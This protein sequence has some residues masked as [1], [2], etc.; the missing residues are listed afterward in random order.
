MRPAAIIN[1]T[2]TTGLAGAVVLMAVNRDSFSV[3]ALESYLGAMGPWGILLF[4]ITYV[5]ATVLMAP[6]TIF[7]LAGGVLFGPYLGTFVN[8]FAA[9]TGAALAFLIARYLASDWVIKKAGRRLAKIIEGVEQEGWR[10]VTLVRLVPLFPFN[11]TNYALGLTRL[12]FFHYVAASFI[13]MLPGAAAYTYLGYAGREAMAGAEGAI[14]KGLLGLGLVAALIF[15]PRLI[16]RLRPGDKKTDGEADQAKSLQPAQPKKAFVRKLMP[17][18]KQRSLAGKYTLWVQVLSLAAFCLA[19]LG[20][21]NEVNLFWWDTPIWLNRYTEYV[22]ILMF[23]LWRISAERNPYTRKRLMVLVSCVTVL[24]WLIPWAFPFF[25]PYTGFLGTQPVFPALH[26]PG[27]VTFFL[28]LGAVFLFGRRVICGWNCPCVGIRETVGFPFRHVTPRGKWAW[29]L[30][31]TKWIFFVLYIVAGAAVILPLNSWTV[32]FLGIF[33]MLVVLPYFASMLLSPI[34][35]NRGYCRYLCP[36]G[37]TFGALNRIGFFRIDFDP[38][39]CNDCGLCSQV[40][41]MGIPVLAQGRA[42]NKIDVAD[43]M[44]CGRCVTECAK[45]SLAF[46]DVRTAINPTI[47]LSRT[48][49]RE[50]AEE[51][52]TL[53][54]WRPWA[55]ASLMVLALASGWGISAAVGGPT[56]LPTNIWTAALC[57][58]H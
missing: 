6:G 26:T 52:T 1:I 46:V 54:D 55:F 22:I 29:R 50:W 2:L 12:N 31:H 5:A 53:K 43:C 16:K 14:Q 30:R 37:A 4:F 11:L 40:C 57:L 17:V 44:G 18:S 51:K 56:E 9:T 38:K 58:V 24:W 15:L 10:F 41:D 48:R 39:T 13:C 21:L 20:W 25:E 19:F 47:M 36:Y 7:A 35:G 33:G 49:L 23:G 42:K 27:T 45:D 28:V 32:T 8:L 34:I 3:E